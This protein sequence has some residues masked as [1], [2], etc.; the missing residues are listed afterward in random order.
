MDGYSALLFEKLHSNEKKW[1]DNENCLNCIVPSSKKVYVHFQEV[2]IYWLWRQGI[3]SK[4]V[5]ISSIGS[6]I[7]ASQARSVTAQNQRA[8]CW[9]RSMKVALLKERFFSCTENWIAQCFLTALHSTFCI[10]DEHLHLYHFGGVMKR[11]SRTRNAAKKQAD[12]SACQ[13][14]NASNKAVPQIWKRW[15]ILPFDVKSK[16]LQL[17]NRAC[18]RFVKKLMQILKLTWFD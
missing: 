4:M 10:K 12:I 14:K 1:F 18:T 2:P 6:F 5:L 9:E 11:I 3:W 16:H 15:N 7:P 8:N 17:Q 13:D